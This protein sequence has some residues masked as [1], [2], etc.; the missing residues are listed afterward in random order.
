MPKSGLLCKNPKTANVIFK[1]S[2]LS[3]DIV[4]VIDVID[5]N[6]QIKYLEGYV[7][8]PDS[9]SFTWY[10]TSID[11][12]LKFISDRKA[13]NANYASIVRILKKGLL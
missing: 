11:K 2:G 7:F 9:K 6:P 12:Q 13:N 4:P 3:V 1:V 8:Q 5:L 10:V